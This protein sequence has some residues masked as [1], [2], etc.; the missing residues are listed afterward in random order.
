MSLSIIAAV[1]KNN[2]IGNK[3]GLLWKIPADMSFFK[4]T[5]TGRT[6]IM[7]KKTFLSIGRPLPNRKNVVVT[8][9][10]DFS[11]EGVTVLHAIEDVVA[12]HKNTDDEVFIIGGGEI[13][14]QLFPHTS[15]LYITHVDEAFSGDTFFPDIDS[16]VWD[17]VGAEEFEKS[18]RS[19]YRLEFSRY[20]R[21]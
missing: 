14:K 9:D 20:E 18:E 7:G 6:I 5:T 2:C 15:R 13:Y 3:N 1:S 4:E 21:K 12:A 11:A 17:K 10:K 19:P 8:R 16:S